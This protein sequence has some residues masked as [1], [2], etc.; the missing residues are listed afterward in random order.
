MLRTTA[1]L[2][3]ALAAPCAVSA[4]TAVSPSTASKSTSALDAANS[5]ISTC[6]SGITTG[7]M[8]P[9]VGVEI[10]TK[11]VMPGFKNFSALPVLIKRFVAHSGSGLTPDMVLQ[12]HSAEGQIWAI[13]R[14][15]T[16]T[17]DIAFTGFANAAIEAQV[18]GA[19]SDSGWVTL[20]KRL[21]TAT[22]PLGQYLFIKRLPTAAAPAFGARA[23]L[24]SAGTT[25]AS[26]GGIQMDI[27][28]VAGDLQVPGASMAPA[29]TDR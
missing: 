1:L 19:F 8:A 3:S 5:A 17:C 7:K 13:V 22:A 23:R 15:S 10:Y 2:L 12:F 4:Q 9:K 11:P 29:P 27:N 26:A 21:G 25:M 24:R 28:F 14:A 16:A 6:M 18:A 20:A